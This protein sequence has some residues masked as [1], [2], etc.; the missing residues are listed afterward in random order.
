MHAF[1]S[2]NLESACN[3]FTF[4]LPVFAHSFCCCQ[5]GTS[6]ESPQPMDEEAEEDS[7]GRS[8][9]KKKSK[10]ARAA[11]KAKEPAMLPQPMAAI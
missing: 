11:K 7:E 10:A 3:S 9:V 5:E 1:K 8:P 6:K 2:C 4:S